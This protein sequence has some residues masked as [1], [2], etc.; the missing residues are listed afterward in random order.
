MSRRRT[1]CVVKAIGRLSRLVRDRGQYIFN[2]TLPMG[3]KEAANQKKK[4]TSM[5]DGCKCLNY[6]SSFWNG[7]Y[8][9]L[10]SST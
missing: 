1:V 5:C 7:G 10:Y 6:V 8:M 9:I 2:P 4:K 3:H